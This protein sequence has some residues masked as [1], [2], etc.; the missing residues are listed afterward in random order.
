M[1]VDDPLPFVECGEEVSSDRYLTDLAGTAAVRLPERPLGHH[2]VGGLV[3]VTSEREEDV[4]ALVVPFLVALGHIGRE[5]TEG[6]DLVRAPSQ[7]DA[8]YILDRGPEPF[9]IIGVV[10]M[11]DHLSARGHE[12]EIVGHLGD[13][14]RGQM[15]GYVGPL[16][17][18]LPGH[19]LLEGGP[20]LEGLRLPVDG[21]LHSLP[22]LGMIFCNFDTISSSLS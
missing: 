9:G 14:L 18:M 3:V 4:I 20:L 13:L 10:K 22:S 1:D 2:D 8:F 7:V 19:R 12:C 21:Y 16:D 15:D 5:R 11:D 6:G 17:V